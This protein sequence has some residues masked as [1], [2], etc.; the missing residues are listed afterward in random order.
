MSA[1]ETPKQPLPPAPPFRPTGRHL[2]AA[3]L[4]WLVPGLGHGMLGFRLSGTILFVGLVG[5]FWCGESVLGKNLP[6]SRKA[7]PIFFSLQMGNGLSTMVANAAF[8]EPRRD[9]GVMTPDREIPRH[10][11]LGIL[12]CTISGLI[13]FLA[14]VHVLDP[15]TWAAA[16]R[17]K[18][19]RVGRGPPGDPE[20]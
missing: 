1:S 6:V 20:S 8:G 17:A 18:A 12:F 13:N 7:S 9:S 10:F 5:L 15:R 3:L 2:A 11:Q 16:E 4:G 19:G 14:V